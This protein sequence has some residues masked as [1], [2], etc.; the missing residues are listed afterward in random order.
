MTKIRSSDGSGISDR[1][2]GFGGGM[3]GMPML[4]VGGG[5]GGLL[6]LILFVVVPQLTGGGGQGA[7]DPGA[8]QDGA[9]GATCDSEQEQI[10]CGAVQDVQDYWEGEMPAAFGTAYQ[11]AV[12]T[13][14]SGAVDTGCGQASSQVGPFYCPLDGGVYVDLDFLDQL[15]QQFVGSVSDLATQY[16]IAHEY[17]H[18]VQNLLGT[19]D[20]VNRAQQ[21]DP[22]RANQYSVAL[23]LQADCYAGVWVHSVAERGLLDNAQEVNEALAAAAGVGDDRIQEQVQGRSDPETFTHGTAEQRQQW[24]DTGFTTGDP[25]QCDTFN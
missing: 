10:V 4:P 2:G 22:E 17:G 15:Q 13:F 12:T 25:L 14:F 11:P 18:H 16:I 7:L 23:E 21:A 1:R 19:S 20:Q 24:F 3:R 9:T 6:L 5:I 8:V